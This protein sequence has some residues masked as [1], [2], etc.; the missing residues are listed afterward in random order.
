M[1]NRFGFVIAVE[2]FLTFLVNKNYEPTPPFCSN[3]SHDSTTDR[4]RLPYAQ[5]HDI[6]DINIYDCQKNCGNK[7]F[8]IIFRYVYELLHSP[9]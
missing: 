2:W 3:T 8:Y 6:I 9:N 7:T 1:A 4:S 5:Y